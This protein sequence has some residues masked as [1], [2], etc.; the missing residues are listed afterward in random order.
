MWEPAEYEKRYFQRRLSMGLKSRGD[1]PEPI[2]QFTP[3]ESVPLSVCIE[4]KLRI[5]GGGQA[6][7]F[8]L[9]VWKISQ[10]DMALLSAVRQAPAVK[11][12]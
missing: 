3:F 10:R 1:S 7:C 2:T 9:P 6:S 5:S 4:R 12:A 11:T 8:S